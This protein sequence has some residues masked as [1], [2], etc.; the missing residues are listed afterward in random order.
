[1]AVRHFTSASNEFL[2]FSP[3]SVANLDGGPQTVAYVWRATTVKD[4]AIIYAIDG[5]STI[6]WYSDGFSDGNNFYG[7]NHAGDFAGGNPYA[8]NTWYLTAFTKPGGVG[9]V[10]RHRYDFTAATWQHAD[11]GSPFGDSPNVPYDRIEVG[12]SHVG[13]AFLNGDLALIGVWD[14]VLSDLAIEALIGAPGVKNWVTAGPRILL[15]FYQSDVGTP[16]KCLMGSG[17]NEIARTG[18]TV[19]TGQ[20]PPG[21]GLSLLPPTNPRSLDD[22]QL[23]ALRSL[24]PGDRELNQTALLQKWK[25]DT[26]HTGWDAYVEEMHA[27]CSFFGQ[28]KAH[29]QDAQYT[30]WA[31]LDFFN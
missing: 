20:D 30:T 29:F 11:T 21:F 31:L 3:G 5:A 4:N 10:R 24:Y 18:T 23:A 13:I 15:P 26:G 6:A 16:I 12:R 7:I 25:V 28:P 19:V 14:S 9:Q 17:V 22:V 2:T 1:M 8:I 27:F